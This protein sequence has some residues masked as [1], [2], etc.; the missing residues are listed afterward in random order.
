MRKEKAQTV[1]GEEHRLLQLSSGQLNR[2]SHHNDPLWYQTPEMGA[3]ALIAT[4][5]SKRE[6]KKALRKVIKK[7]KELYK[8]K[9]IQKA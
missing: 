1:K 4:L 8:Q 9:L 3:E 7:R 5:D 2:S 6:I